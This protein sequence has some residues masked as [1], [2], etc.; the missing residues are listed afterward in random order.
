VAAGQRDRDQPDALGKIV[1]GDDVE[2]AGYLCAIG[3]PGLRVLT[4]SDPVELIYLSAV[5]EVVARRRQEERKAL[6]VE[7]INALSRA[8]K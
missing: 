8:M 1:G 3:L 7:V 4:S 5:A 2:L 6:A